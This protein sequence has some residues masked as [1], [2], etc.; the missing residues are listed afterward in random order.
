MTK[1]SISRK[2]AT[3]ISLKD[4]STMKEQ[5]TVKNLEMILNL[6]YNEITIR[7]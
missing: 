6:Y 5:N 4:L 7:V 2:I 1:V 3:A